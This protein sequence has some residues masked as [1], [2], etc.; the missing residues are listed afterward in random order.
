MMYATS[1]VPNALVPKSQSTSCGFRLSRFYRT[2]LLLNRTVICRKLCLLTVAYL[3]FYRRKFLVLLGGTFMYACLS[4]SHICKNVKNVSSVKVHICVLSLILNTTI[5]L[6]IT[7]SLVAS[8]KTNNLKTLMFYCE[9]N[10]M[11]I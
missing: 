10:L 4:V 1:H 2:D 11:I 6:C 5:A 9:K 7:V 3:Q 8:M